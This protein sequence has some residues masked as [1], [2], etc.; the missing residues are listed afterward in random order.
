MAWLAVNK[1]NSEIISEYKPNRYDGYWDELVMIELP[2]GS[3]RR[4][5]GID[6]TW[7]DEPIELI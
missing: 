5:T 2:I 6:M 4:L 3:I 1:D 7:N